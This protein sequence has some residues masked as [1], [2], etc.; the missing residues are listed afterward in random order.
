MAVLDPATAHRMTGLVSIATRGMHQYQRPVAIPALLSTK[1]SNLDCWPRIAG[2]SGFGG[3][4]FLFGFAI[5]VSFFLGLVFFIAF[6]L[7]FT[8]IFFESFSVF[9]F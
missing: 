2:N 9:F 3:F 1:I 5:F 7:F 6:A 8:T 4:F